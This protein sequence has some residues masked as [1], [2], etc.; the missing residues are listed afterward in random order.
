QIHTHMAGTV[1]NAQRIG[2]AALHQTQI[3]HQVD[4]LVGRVSSD[5]AQNASAS[6]QLSATVSEV[7]STASELSHIA[8]SIRSE[9][10]QFRV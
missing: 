8:E 1:E 4:A 9:V 7:A 5:V 6:H 3:S 10:A 2:A